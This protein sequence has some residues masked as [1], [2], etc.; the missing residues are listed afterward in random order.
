MVEQNKNDIILK[1]T[2]LKETERLTNE[3]KSIYEVNHFQGPMVGMSGEEYWQLCKWINDYKF[4]TILDFGSG[5]G[6]SWYMMNKFSN[7]EK[8]YPM[9]PFGRK[10]A[11]RAYYIPKDV[12]I[13]DFRI[14]ENLDKFNLFLKTHDIDFVLLDDGHQVHIVR[15]EIETCYDNNIKYVAIHDTKGKPKI[16]VR[17]CKDKYNIID[18]N[19]FGNGLTLLKIK[20]SV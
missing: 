8:I 12:K 18:E 7:A 4:K 15:M 10:D 14:P 1:E 19:N 16:A 5:C 17:K 9:E 6:A 11:W 3:W 20:K 2:I 13:Y